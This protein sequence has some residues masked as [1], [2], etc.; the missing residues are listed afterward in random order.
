MEIV[1]LDGEA[2]NRQQSKH[3]QKKIAK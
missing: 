3:K 2:E 1:T